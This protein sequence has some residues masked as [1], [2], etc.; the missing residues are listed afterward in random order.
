MQSRG[1]HRGYTGRWYA[2]GHV[3]LSKVLSLRQLL[4]SE[5]IK[6]REP[7]SLQCR[8]LVFCS[9]PRY[10][11]YAFDTFHGTEE[12]SAYVFILPGT[13]RVQRS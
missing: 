13:T 4:K 9:T 7:F 1:I 8:G 12:T 10:D 3:V 2:S 5:N 11:L 6:G